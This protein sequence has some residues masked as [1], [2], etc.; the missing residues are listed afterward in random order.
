M[1]L[2]KEAWLINLKSHF[3]SRNFFLYLIIGSFAVSV[4]TATFYILYKLTKQVATN[5]I[6]Y[7]LGTITSFTLNRK[8]NFKVFDKSHL[9]FLSFIIVNTSGSIIST[10]LIWVGI[11]IFNTSP[12]F[13]KLFTLPL[14][15]AYQYTLNKLITFK[16][17]Q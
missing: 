13:A 8:F 4:D 6:S 10:T 9:R 12:L 2:V 7:F 15:L 5:F 11:T 14:I 1:K 17:Y 16:R 3:L